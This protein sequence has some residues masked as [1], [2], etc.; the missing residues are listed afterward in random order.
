MNNRFL[1]QL[2]NLKM[3]KKS[4]GAVA[5]TAGII[6]TT[7]I[8]Q[9]AYAH[10]FVEKPGSRSALCSPT[11]GAL[12][13]NCGSVMYEPQ[14][15]E[16][17]KGFPQGGP[18]DGQ[19]ASAGGKFGGILDQQAAER[20]FKNTITG[21]E[22]TFTWKYTAPHLT[23]KWHYYI[24][25]KGWN[26]NKAL[27][28]ADFEP[29]GTVQHDGSAASNNVTHKINVPT[30]RSGYHV[31]LAVWDVADTVNAFYNVID[32]N[33]INDVKPDTEAPSIPNG[34]QAQKVTANSIELTWNTST[35]NVG[36][37]GYQIFRNGEMIDTVLGTHF[38]DK[39]LQP[40]T[41][42]SYTVKAIDAAGNV[43][44]E[45]TAFTAKT[46]VEAPDTE[47]PT[48]P[49]GLHSMG[50]TASSVDLMWSPSDDN[51]GVDHYDIYRETEGSMKKIATSNTTSY[52]D[53]NLLAN[54]TYK[55][56]VKAVDVVGN[57][58]VQSD[59][60]TITTKTESASHEE[61][62]AKKAYKKGDR[63]LHEGKV[64]EA[65]QN[66][67]GHGDPNWIFALSLWKAV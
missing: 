1:K 20:W 2:Q 6:G 28:R 65:F 50:T 43:S 39:K 5:L 35:D 51:V 48:Q 21:G 53:R 44:K 66:Y 15:L 41:E 17:P 14:S 34:I 60:F 62:D 9:N 32:V 8:P 24:T 26:P 64:Y 12:N 57:E 37:K 52:M 10:G 33:L 40:S 42:Y 11:Y 47:A 29:I 67:E 19:I 30:D 16:A 36:V 13:V 18:V 61:W 58:S 46:T 59:T 55:Y 27:T 63:V 4:I 23:S 3:N 54:T 56:V 31:I 49:K 45:S 38:I 7:L 22:N 25:K